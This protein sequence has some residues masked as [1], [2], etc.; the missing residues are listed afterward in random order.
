MKLR[1]LNLVEELAAPDGRLRF[2]TTQAFLQRFGLASV[3][4]THDIVRA[5]Y[6]ALEK[7]AQDHTASSL[8]R[9]QSPT[10][11]VKDTSIRDQRNS[12]PRPSRIAE[13]Y[14]R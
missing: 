4:A 12:E 2:A 8:T 6:K 9:Q 3:P 5:A 14:S 13:T 7:F 11:H 10:F 1:D